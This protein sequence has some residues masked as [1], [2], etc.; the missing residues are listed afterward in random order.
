MDKILSLLVL[1]LSFGLT[2]FLLATGLTLTMGLMRVVNMSHGALYLLSGFLGVAVYNQTENW[3][4]SL[5]AATVMAAVLGLLIEVGFL[6][7]LYKHPAYQV[8]LTIGIINIINN[9]TLWIWGGYPKVP[10]IPEFLRGGVKVGSVDIP[11]FRFF[12]IGFGIVMA[13]LLWLLQD[14]TK[15]GAM[16]R[17]GMDNREVAGTLGMNNKVIFTAVFVLGSLIAGLSSM[18]GGTITGINMTT[19]WDV[20]LS[21][22]IVVVVGG[23]GSIQGALL[24]GVIIGLVN[25]FGA[26]YYSKFS[27]F[28]IY[29]VLIIILL[30]KP[31]GLLG[32]KTD[33]NR[34]VEGELEIGSSPKRRFSKLRAYK[35]KETVEEDAPQVET[36]WKQKAYRWA[37]YIFALLVLTIIPNF[38]S[39]YTQGMMTKVLV[40]ALFAMSLD[41]VMG[42]TGMR[43][44]GHAAFFGVGG[45]AVGL[46]A[47]HLGITSFWLLLPIT[48]VICAIASAV[49]G[50]FTLRVSGVH[51]L[52]VTMAFGQLLSVIASK[53]DKV[54]GG[55]DGLIG[56]PRPELGFPINWKSDPAIKTYFFVLVI[57]II[58]Y[59]L[60]HCFMRS[61]YGRALIG[62]RENEGRMRSLGYN[63][64]SL[65]YMGVI[66]AGIFAGVAGLLYAYY[67]RTMIPR[68]LALETSAL[69]MLM[70]IMGGAGTLWGPAL[71]AVVII[72][73]QNYA[74]VYA[75]ERWPLI[76]GILYVLCVMFLRGGFARYLTN[77]WDWAGR[78][79]FFRKIAPQPVCDEADGEEVEP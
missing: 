30:I 8:L 38:F 2:Y 35:E 54:T 48:V 65:K 15:V 66:L 31:S 43:S 17:A 56:I 40:F 75:T 22:I 42:Y 11:Y 47:T 79:I 18:I 4:L 12:I 14:K 32:R 57:F 24:G 23:T 16:V 13:V 1:G 19:G 51:F 73:V 78:R 74:S 68:D 3:I 5:F 60:L 71:G 25:T 69:P 36:S 46:F 64:W 62:V 53:W 20:L 59:I 34:A 6:R 63:T 7:R 45:Y 10:P 52:L 76:L 67:Y 50:Y 21:S 26:A 27:S 61:S 58:C 77:L 9:V 29:A 49:I 44:F 41:I 28:I 37:P 55:T 33:V 72:L 39:T 70:V